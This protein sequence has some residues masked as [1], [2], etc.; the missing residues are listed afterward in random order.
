MTL[1]CTAFGEV[2]LRLDPAGAVRL[3]QA[4]RFE[5][6]FTGAEANVAASL[7]QFG[8]GARVVSAVPDDV[9]GEASLAFLRRFG[10]DVTGVLRLPGRLGLFYLEP[11]GAGRPGE[12]IYDRANSVFTLTGPDAYDWAAILGGQDWLHV[13]GTVAAVGPA[14]AAALD[15]AL[16]EAQDAGVRV[17]LDVN[18]R[19]RLWSAEQ[20]GRVLRPFLDRVDVLLGAGEELVTILNQPAPP[21]WSPGLPLSTEQRIALMEEARDR[22]GLRAV[23]GTERSTGEAALRGLLSTVEGTAVSQAR[24]LMDERG[25]VGTGDAYAA[26]VIRGLLLGHAAQE[27]V[28]FAAA[29]AHLKQSI[30]GDVN[31]AS[32]A[33]VEHALETTGPARLRR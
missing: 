31:I 7:A 22:F 8:I 27:V 13:S 25:R 28:E 10:V 17:S 32:V 6:R 20:A 23:A 1:S 2:M 30:A 3:I 19:S 16:A 9:L 12:V 11:G 5:I 4:D 29:A 21:G 15:R 33:E 18:Y 14:A 24:R 26:G